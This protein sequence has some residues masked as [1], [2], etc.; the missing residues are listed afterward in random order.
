MVNRSH[1]LVATSKRPEGMSDTQVLWRL[2]QIAGTIYSAKLEFLA[3]VDELA[4]EAIDL[5]LVEKR[6]GNPSDAEMLQ[7]DAY[8]LIRQGIEQAN[9]GLDAAR[10]GIDITARAFRME[11]RRKD[12]A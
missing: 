11:R 12:K 9:T 7:C 4:E 6:R 2:Q 1:A 3:K 8:K 10:T 5:A